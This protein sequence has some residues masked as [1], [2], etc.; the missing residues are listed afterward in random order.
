MS[1]EINP[2][3][4]VESR[5]NFYRCRR[6]QRRQARTGWDDFQRCPN[7]EDSGAEQEKSCPVA[8]ENGSASCV[9]L[10][11][12]R[13]VTHHR[14]CENR[15]TFA[16]YDCRSIPNVNKPKHCSFLAHIVLCSSQFPQTKGH[17]RWVPLP[18]EPN[19]RSRDSARVRAQ[20]YFSEAS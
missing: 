12:H 4:G 9:V 19:S 7:G 8:Q 14:H 11:E 16:Y 20:R 15:S 13:D 1:H 18:V 2:L 10:P 6:R 5:S 17:N 3:A